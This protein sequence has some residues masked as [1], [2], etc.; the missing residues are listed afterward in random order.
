MSSHRLQQVGAFW[1]DHN[2]CLFRAWAPRARQ[3]ELLLVPREEAIPMQPGEHGYFEITVPVA[4]GAR[5][6][7]RL[8]GHR[9][10][11]DPASRLQ[12][13]GVHQPSAV[14]PAQ[15]SWSDAGW[16]GV[17]LR[18]YVL[19]EL[20]VGAFTPEGTFDAV[21]PHLDRLA[22]LGVTAV[23]LMPV[24]A[25]PGER[26]WGYDGVYPF[27]VQASY[28]G[29]DGLKRLV[30]ACHARG[31]AVVL[32]V[33]YNHLGPEGNYLAEFGPY[34]TD[35][36]KTPWGAALNFHGADSGPVRD[37]FIQN[38]LQWVTEF[39]IDGLRLDAV[40][41]IVDLSPRHILEEI[42]EHVAA[43]AAALDRTVPVI[44]ESDLNDPRLLRL[45]EAGGYG[46]DAQWSDDFHHCLHVL[47][48]GERRGYYADF[49]GVEQ[50]AK[51]MREGYCY[52]G[53]YSRYRQRPHGAPPDDI[54]PERFVVFSQNHDQVG[55]RVR[56]DRLTALVGFEELKLAAAATILSPFIPLLFMGEEYGE[57]EDFPYFV[58]HGDP[59]LIEAVRRGRREE[60]PEF[61]LAG[62]APDPQAIATFESGVLSQELLHTGRHAVLHQFYKELLRLRRDLPGLAHRG[63]QNME[64]CPDEGRRLV[65]S[66]RWADGPWHPRPAGAECLLYF[67]FADKA[68][69]V[70]RP[71]GAWRTALD[72]AHPRWNG[73]LAAAPERISLVLQPKSCLVLASEVAAE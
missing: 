21:V 34:F 14:Q 48:T 9:R 66:R 25:F 45:P 11:P 20:H 63:K 13:D 32:D 26:N 42:K 28:G 61:A 52:T 67:S 7:F 73:P 54:P 50:F 35:L 29:P 23:E 64:V 41:A 58:S 4:P 19:Y 43:R 68:Q 60:F 46:L 70:P 44:A 31:L 36:H 1:Q 57:P 40:H 62:D 65:V 16:R 12:P 22:D 33:V 72:S 18:D 27:A 3:V 39:H 56:G 15:F 55:N 10:L 37:Y 53:E 59:S 51:T 49:D 71:A 24:A 47:L 38:A 69:T 17:P 8:D 2:H 5:Y 6:L 30:D